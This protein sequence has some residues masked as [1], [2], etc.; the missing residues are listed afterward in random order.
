[1]RTALPARLS[2]R[3]SAA[4]ALAL[5]PA[6]LVAS[7]PAA[8]AATAMATRPASFTASAKS[9]PI[10][11]TVTFKAQAQQLRAKTWRATP[12]ATATV[13]F[14]QDGAKA[15]TAMRTIKADA[16]GNFSTSFSASASGVWTIRLAPTATLQASTSAPIRVNVTIPA[17]TRPASGSWNCPSWAPIKGNA[18]SHIYHV[19][20]G[21]YYAKTKPEICFSSP[22]AAVRAG[23]RASKA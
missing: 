23:Y 7:A 6:A 5:I 9:V 15:N 19:P 14:D 10:T 2:A 13:W 21:R 3:V 18:S 11:S 12:G 17:S 1:M 8:S 16:K 20:G 4:A 22:A